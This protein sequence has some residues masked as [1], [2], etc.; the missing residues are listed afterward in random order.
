MKLTSLP[1]FARLG[2]VLG[3]ALLLTWAPLR[4]QA[5]SNTSPMETAA[6]YAVLMDAESGEI[7]YE[8]NADVPMAPASM[9]KLMT[10]AVVFDAIKQ[11]MLT[12]DDTFTV[13]RNAWQKQ[14]SKM[15]VL[16]G[17][18]ISVADLLRGIIIQSGNDA[19]IVIAEGMD[20]NE[21]AFAVRMT[22]FGEEIG[23]TG[24]VFRNSTGWPDPEHVMSARDLGIV[25]R[26]IIM[27]HP[28]LYMLFSE[29]EFK[30]SNIS[31][32]NRNP[33]LLMNMGAD[34]LKTGHTEAS[35]YGLVG[36]AVRGDRRIIVVLNGMRSGSQRA[37]ESRRMLNVGFREYKSLELF[38]A[39]AEVGRAQVWKGERARVPLMV[40]GPVKVNIHR[41]ARK[42]LKVRLIYTGPVEAPISTG[43]EIGILEMVAP[44]MTTKS[45][46][47]FAAQD[48]ARAG[49][50]GRV[51]EGLSFKLYGLREG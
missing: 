48:V 10:I 25:A 15:W 29:T 13:S 35:G 37:K 47:V 3:L 8:K 31:Q 43:D 38:E 49:F 9:S 46:P 11:G 27:E 17:T 24:S 39:G 23:L 6:N 33:L 21:E 1:H 45:V 14:G 42:G 22:R 50:V 41:R 4:A 19:C 32:P 40:Q 51:I 34:G 7:F 5:Q 28:E 2:T 30:W 12:L 18:E 16:V 44:G 36:S 26:Y 20:G